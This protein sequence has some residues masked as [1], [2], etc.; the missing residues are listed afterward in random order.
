M[1]VLHYIAVEAEDVEEATDIVNSCI[2]N[3]TFDWSDWAVI[4]G[5]WSGED[6]VISYEEKPEKFL[7]VLENI[8]NSKVQEVKSCLEKVDIQHVMSLLDNYNGEE[9][10]FSTEDG[11]QAYRLRT[12]LR[13]V[14]GHSTPDS[15]FYDDVEGDT[16]DKY[17]KRRVKNNPTEQYLVAVDFHY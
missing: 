16:S 8:R 9:L 2:E 17:I 1:H 3:N 13:I 5:R 7:E 15:Y 10:P 4:G 12:A 6:V 11:M 14:S